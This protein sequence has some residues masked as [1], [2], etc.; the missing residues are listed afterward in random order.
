MQEEKREFVEE[1]IRE[2][3]S[4]LKVIFKKAVSFIGL[5][6]VF[7]LGVALVIFLLR[8]NLKELFLDEE[9][10][11]EQPIAKE[12]TVA[13]EGETRQDENHMTSL[14]QRINKSMTAIYLMDNDSPE[15]QL[16]CSGAVLSADTN[17][18]ILVS[19][20]KVKNK[21]DMVAK[22]CDGSTADAA[23]WNKDSR[24]G[25]AILQVKNTDLQEDTR[26]QI[27]SVTIGGNQLET[28]NSIVYEGNAF[29]EQIL[30]YT[31]SIAGISSASD[32]Y[33]LNGRWIYTDLNLEKMEEGFLFSANAHLVGMVLGNSHNA[34]NTLTAMVM[35]DAY[36]VIYGLVNKESL[37][38]I[39]VQ[40]ENIDAEKYEYL[41]D[42]IPTGLYVTS[43]DTT[44]NAC[45]AGIMVGDIITK[46]N[47]I[48]INDMEDIRRAID[49]QN[50]G[51]T[52]RVQL[53]R[54]MGDDY[55]Q[56]NVNVTIGVRD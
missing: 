45:I 35:Y 15:Q 48:E 51:D 43:L 10:T 17:I 2:K 38:Y 25:I 55:K 28:G 54:R 3:P 52:V 6:V 56:M 5:A 11:Q 23:L 26:N 42:N 4:L 49:S 21:S 46:I 44:G 14:E 20:D 24:L 34:G 12:I 19:Y 33:D 7:G 39:G 13:L 16:L 50:T 18:Y 36:N 30:T 8:N 47:D 53:Y 31:G 37:G 27:A 22:F 41:D 40:G 1:V 32:T 29:E 9:K